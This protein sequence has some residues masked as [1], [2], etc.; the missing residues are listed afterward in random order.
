MSRGS[1]PPSM[2]PR[3][4][5]GPAAAVRPED[6]L[7]TAPEHACDAERKGEARVVLLPLDGVHRLPRDLEPLGEVR[8]RPLALGAEHAEPVLHFF[9]CRGAGGFA[10]GFAGAFPGAA[11][12]AVAPVRRAIHVATVSSAAGANVSS[13]VAYSATVPS[14]QVWKRWLSCGILRI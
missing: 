3:P 12:G 14:S 9:P 5:R 8:L 11:A 10:G 1:R 4:E 13:S 6:L 7:D 2:S